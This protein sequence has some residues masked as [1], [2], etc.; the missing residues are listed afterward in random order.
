LLPKRRIV[1]IANAKTGP[2]TGPI[3]PGLKKPLAAAKTIKV[4]QI[5]AIAKANIFDSLRTCG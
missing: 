5:D 2:G 4:T 1:R 3:A